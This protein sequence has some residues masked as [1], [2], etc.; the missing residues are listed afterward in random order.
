MSDAS[1]CC[2]F[3]NERT[4][5]LVSPR[6]V[7][8]Q[9]KSRGPGNATPPLCRVAD[10]CGP[11]QA[12]DATAYAC[13]FRRCAT[14]RHMAPEA[15][16][17]APKATS[18]RDEC[19]SAVG[20]TA[21]ASAWPRRAGCDVPTSSMWWCPSDDHPA[22]VR[23]PSRHR[24]PF[25]GSAFCLHCGCCKS[26]YE[27]DSLLVTTLISAAPANANCDSSLLRAVR[28]WSATHCMRGKWLS[29]TSSWARS[30]TSA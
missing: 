25:S 15:K 4:P 11:P 13:A 6:A 5:R 26:M 20:L 14:I 17:A 24:A 21:A 29:G 12:N 3:T 9:T 8:V 7:Q 30:V 23:R 18:A 10:M 1:T 28:M 27:S 2:R 16:Q 19:C 22:L